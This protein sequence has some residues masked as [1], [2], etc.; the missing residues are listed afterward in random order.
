MALDNPS[1]FTLPGTS[2]S[3]SSFSLLKKKTSS[4]SKA[5]Q[6]SNSVNSLNA[7]SPSKKLTR[8]Q[9]A[10][11]DLENHLLCLGNP[12]PSDIDPSIKYV[13]RRSH[14]VSQQ[15]SSLSS[16]NEKFA[17]VDMV[18]L[19]GDDDG[20]VFLSSFSDVKYYNVPNKSRFLG[21]N[22][23]RHSI[24]GYLHKDSQQLTAPSGGA[25]HKTE[26]ARRRSS[27]SKCH[28]ECSSSSTIGKSA[29]IMITKYIPS[30]SKL[31]LF[32]S[33][34]SNAFLHFS[35]FNSNAFLH[36]SSFNSNTS[37]E[38]PSE[39]PEH[40]IMVWLGNL[41]QGDER[42]YPCWR[43]SKPDFSNA[44]NNNNIT[45][46]KNNN[47]NNNNNNNT[48]TTTTTTPTTTKTHNNNK[49][50]Q[51]QQQQ[52]QQAHYHLQTAYSL[53]LLL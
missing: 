7:H 13:H 50:K 23:R 12:R 30:L 17:E 25:E 49:T 27:C 44:V 32:N 53:G 31:D 1:Y 3:K 47:N 45:N 37:L 4:P 38:F 42:V 21:P 5:S 6:R 9:S 39:L 36:F 8:S 33:F 41:K 48:T 26:S 16:A 40:N 34:N 28:S 29:Y 20:E 19:T 35:S 51:Q 14:S 18:H 24:G 15:R 52:Q 11:S 46:N 10:T 22:K 43:S 2:K